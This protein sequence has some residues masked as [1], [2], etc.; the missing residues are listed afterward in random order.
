MGPVVSVVA[1]VPG[2]VVVVDVDDYFI[3][4]V[5]HRHQNRDLEPK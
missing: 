3:T 5:S 2:V 4:T 1:A